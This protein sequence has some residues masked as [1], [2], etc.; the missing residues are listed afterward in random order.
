LISTNIN[1]NDNNYQFV[2]IVNSHFSI[3][4]SGITLMST[5]NWIIKMHLPDHLIS[6]LGYVNSRL[7]MR[8]DH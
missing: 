8:N 3:V 1:R 7:M 5:I 4:M 6:W 2:N